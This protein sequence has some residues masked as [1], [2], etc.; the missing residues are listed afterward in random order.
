MAWVDRTS[1][2]WRELIAAHPESLRIACD[3]RDTR[4]VGEL[5]QHIVAAEL[6]YAERLSGRTETPYETVEYGSAAAIYATHD[7][8]MGYLQQLD[9]HPEAYWEEW[10]EFR[11]RSSGT[12]R[13][14]RRTI[15]L[16]LLMHSIRH[17]AQLATLLRQHGIAPNW[18][19]D[20]LFMGVTSLP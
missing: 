16:H 18:A 4:S 3:I 6:R 15:F 17:Y 13:A 19:M 5:L 7:K 8:A 9:A 12:M 10:I 2:G 14:T 20:Y 1:V 11:T